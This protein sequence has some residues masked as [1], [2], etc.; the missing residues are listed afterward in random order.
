[1][2]MILF[3]L[4]A[5]AVMAVGEMFG[6]RMRGTAR[7][8]NEARMVGLANAYEEDADKW[9]QLAPLGE[10]PHREGMQRIDEAAVKRMENSF[11]SFLNKLKN[12]FAG[13]PVYEGHP[14][15]PG[16]Q[17]QYPDKRAH[18]WIKEMQARADGLYARINWGDSGK[19]MLA[20]GHYKFHSPYFEAD[21][22]GF[23]RGRKVYRPTQV[24]SVGLT[25]Y[26]NIP[27]NPLTNTKENEMD[28]ALL[29]AALGLAA[30]ATDADITAAIGGLKSEAGKVTTLA[31]DLTAARGTQS[32]AHQTE[33]V[34]HGKTKTRLDNVV[35]QRNKIALDNAVDLGHITPAQRAEWEP[36]LDADFDKAIGE[37]KELKGGMKTAATTANAGSRRT[38][39]AN[40]EEQTVT[41]KVQTLVTKEMK[42][43]GCTYQEAFSRVRLANAAL[44]ETAE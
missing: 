44:F 39:L 43:S 28:R 34:E 22:I 37:I 41:A 19:A 9:V 18:G 38:T 11:N 10:F 30:T 1:M 3:A 2:K 14:D 32:A 20:N 35:K 4:A 12:K 8:A 7:L 15:V 17:T 26:P 21:E 36:K 33:C 23:E 42:D 24:L 5:F 16:L 6:R 31:N 40:A 29:I 13:V 25:N 27:V